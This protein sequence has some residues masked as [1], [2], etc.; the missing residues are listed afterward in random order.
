MTIFEDSTDKDYQYND[1]HSAARGNPKLRQC[2]VWTQL[3]LIS[4]FLPMI[5]HTG[6]TDSDGIVYDFAGPFTINRNEMAFGRPL[7]YV[8]LNKDGAISDQE[9]DKSV[10]H[11]NGVYRQRTHSLCC[12][13]CHSH[14]AM[15]LNN[16]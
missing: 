15:V 12:D 14:V 10:A 8:K 11:A 5:G 4:W 2:I 9:W 13:N 16:F 6:I 3:P 7:K 1:I